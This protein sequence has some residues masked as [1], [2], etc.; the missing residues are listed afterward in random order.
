MYLKDKFST[1][2]WFMKDSVRFPTTRINHILKFIKTAFYCRLVSK[3]EKK[4]FRLQLA[5]LCIN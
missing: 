3:T 1:L 2:E 4:T 5:F